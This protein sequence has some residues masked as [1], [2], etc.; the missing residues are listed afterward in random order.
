MP[1]RT[2]TPI[3]ASCTRLLY[4]PCFMPYHSL[5]R[6]YNAYTN[7]N[8]VHSYL[9]FHSNKSSLLSTGVQRYNF[10]NFDNT[11]VTKNCS[12]HFRHF[13][14]TLESTITSAQIG[15]SVTPPTISCN[16]FEADIIWSLKQ[17]I[18]KK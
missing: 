11:M 10:D 17:F 7:I 14:S 16:I 12:R 5:Q 6:I 13:R 1:P 4:L 8:R 18:Q 15:H 3:S 9:C 2:C